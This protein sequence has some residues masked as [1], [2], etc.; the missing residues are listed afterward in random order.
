MYVDYKMIHLE[1]NTIGVIMC[2]NVDIEYMVHT[3]KW[4]PLLYVAWLVRDQCAT[5]D[6]L[7]FSETKKRP[8]SHEHRDVL[9]KLGDGSS[10]NKNFWASYHPNKLDPWQ[11]SIRD[12]LKVLAFSSSRKFTWCNVY[13]I[14]MPKFSPTQSNYVWL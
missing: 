11:S 5:L 2:S 8:K 1:L 3:N 14:R 10:K 13:C 7:L 6:Y 4:M 12:I 9:P